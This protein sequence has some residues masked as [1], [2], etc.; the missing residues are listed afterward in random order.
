MEGSTRHFVGARLV[1]RRIG[2]T[3]VLGHDIIGEH[4]GFDFFAADI[5]KH[6]PIDL[7][8]GAEHL[9]GFLDHLLALQGIVDDIAVFKRE[10]IF[11]ENGANALAPAAARFQ[12]GNDFWF[13]HKNIHP[14]HAIDNQ[15]L[16]SKCPASRCWAKFV[17]L[18]LVCKSEALHKK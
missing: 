14:Q 7:N 8:A 3:I 15:C 10:I 18:N 2:C 11:A 17:Y 16:K 12:I 1:D 13:V 5:G 6:V 4:P 9:A